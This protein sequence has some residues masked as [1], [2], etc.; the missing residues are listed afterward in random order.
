MKNS[1]ASLSPIIAAGLAGAASFA[2]ANAPFTATLPGETLFAIAASAALLA[3]AVA[4]Y[5]RRLEPLAPRRPL[6]RPA[7]PTG[8][9]AS[10][11]HRQERIAA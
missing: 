10:S 1:F 7:L 5:S 9:A 6:L 4:D 2:L 11:G 3:G 8:T